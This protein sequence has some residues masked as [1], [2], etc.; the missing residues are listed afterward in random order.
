[1]GLSAANARTRRNEH[2]EYDDGQEHAEGGRDARQFH[3]DGQ[4][5]PQ[6]RGDG[7]PGT[8]QGLAE[9]RSGFPEQECGQ[10][11]A[12]DQQGDESA[13]QSSVLQAGE[14][15]PIHGV[16]ILQD[17]IDLPQAEHLCELLI[18]LHGERLRRDVGVQS[19]G[20]LHDRFGVGVEIGPPD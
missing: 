10:G 14:R 12:Q 19:P 7:D 15:L 5:A 6:Q 8:D 3:E 18:V 9:Q 4:T 16:G 1:M 2:D 17:G 20:G 13:G 11:E